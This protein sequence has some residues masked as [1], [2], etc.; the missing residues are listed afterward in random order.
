MPFDFASRPPEINSALI[1]AGPGAAPMMAAAAG[2]NNL[3]AEL[4]TAAASYE[5]VIS[6]LAGGEWLGPASL[7]MAASVEPYVQWMNTTAAAAERAAAQATASAVAYQNAYAMTVPPPLIAAN[8]AQLA[9]LIATNILGQNTPAILANEAQYAAMWAQD[10]AALYGYAAASASA[11]QLTPLKA[12]ASTTNPGGTAAQGAAVSTAGTQGQLN[13]LVSTLPSAMQQLAAPADAT[14]SEGFLNDL[15]SSGSNIGIYNS[16]VA[17]IGAGSNAVAWNVFEAIATGVTGNA[18]ST[19]PAAAALAPAALT[20]A[21]AGSVAPSATPVLAGA[22]QAATV[23]RMSVP[24][25]WTAAAPE[26]TT[27]TV[28]AAAWTADVDEGSVTNVATGMPAAATTGR[29]GY[30]VATPRYGV[31]PTVMPTRVLV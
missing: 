12:P 22:G 28:T 4:S 19:A 7:A 5:S 18:A 13:Q 14:T 29:G 26:P 31:K 30:S 10:A 9:T 16:G 20:P 27:E 1:Y 6:E 17:L 21:L 3:A 2:W 11:G 8:R 15:F 23:G 24:A 25:A